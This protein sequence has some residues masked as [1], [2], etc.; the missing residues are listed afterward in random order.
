MIVSKEVLIIGLALA[1]MAARCPAE[2]IDVRTYGVRP[3]TKENMVPAVRRVLEACKG[4]R[5]S[6]IP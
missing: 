4:K 3:D 2:E 1:I 6:I 5:A